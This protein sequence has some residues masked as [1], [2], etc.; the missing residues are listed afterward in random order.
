[1]RK[2]AK[3]DLRWL[4]PRESPCKWQTCAAV[5]APQGDGPECELAESFTYS[6]GDGESVSLLSV[7]LYFARVTSVARVR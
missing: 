4:A 3:A 2:S 7:A 6:Q 5:L 1:M